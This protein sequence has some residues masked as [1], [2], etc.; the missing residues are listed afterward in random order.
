[1]PQAEGLG[2]LALLAADDAGGGHCPPKRTDRTAL[3]GI[4]ELALTDKR[5]S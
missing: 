1:M 5:C 4:A 2:C 3:D